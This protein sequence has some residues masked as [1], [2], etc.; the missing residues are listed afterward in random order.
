MHK[1]VWLVVT[2]MDM[3]AERKAGLGT[4]ESHCQFLATE[5]R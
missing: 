1:F 2:G 3:P 5:V 4:A